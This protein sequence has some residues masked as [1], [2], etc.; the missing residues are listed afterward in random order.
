[1]DWNCPAY[2]ALGLKASAALG[3]TSWLFC[4]AIQINCA[5]PQLLLEHYLRFRQI[6]RTGYANLTSKKCL[7]D[8]GA[9]CQNC[10][11]LVLWILSLL[12]II[13]IADVLITANWHANA[14]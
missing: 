9:D 14:V 13:F 2:L 3:I 7:C 4:Q 8:Q 1:M 5:I 11:T 10:R 6:R 12:T